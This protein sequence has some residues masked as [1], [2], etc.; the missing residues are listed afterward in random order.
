MPFGKD[1][2]H[3]SVRKTEERVGTETRTMATRWKYSPISWEKY[4]ALIC[5]GQPAW[6]TGKHFNTPGGNKGSLE[7]AIT[8]CKAFQS[9]LLQIEKC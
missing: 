7:D 5:P 8:V 9:H 4:H 2:G 6:G 1:L 3:T